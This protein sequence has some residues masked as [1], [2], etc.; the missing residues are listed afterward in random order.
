MSDEQNAKIDAG[1]RDCLKECENLDRP[2]SRLVAFIRILEDDP[3]WTDR[4]IIELL[5]R[6]IRTLM[7]RRSAGA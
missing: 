7:V 3:N 2:F 6:V 4:E 5:T 1:A